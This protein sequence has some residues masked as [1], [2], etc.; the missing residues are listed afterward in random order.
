MRGKVAG[1]AGGF[2]TLDPAAF[3]RLSRTGRS[4][5]VAL[6]KLAGTEPYE[7]G[8][9]QVCAMVGRPTRTVERA[10]AALLRA[11][12]LIEKRVG[13]GTAT[14]LVHPSTAIFAPRADAPIRRRVALRVPK[15]GV[16]LPADSVALRCAAVPHWGW[17]CRAVPIPYLVDLMTAQERA[18]VAY[19]AAT[20]GGPVC[21]DLDLSADLIEH[22]RHLAW[23]EAHAAAE[24]YRGA[25]QHA[26]FLKATDVPH[27]VEDHE[28]AA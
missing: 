26:E 4:V 5:L 17:R 7:S 14:L 12:F 15:G 28:D 18:I 22:F 10:I 25:E 27:V 6:W 23:W 21:D 20:N 3:E 13:P 19:A 11:G 24:R 1:E 16:R 2:S 8:Q 9:A